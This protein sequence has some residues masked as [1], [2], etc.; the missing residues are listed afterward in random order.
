M[1]LFGVVELRG[2]ELHQT[3]PVF[4]RTSTKDQ[5]LW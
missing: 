5:Y 2:V 4:A 1:V 3:S